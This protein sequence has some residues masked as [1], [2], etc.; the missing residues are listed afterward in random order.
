M[1]LDMSLWI[2]FALMAASVGTIVL[3][4]L[5]PARATAQ[6]VNADLLVYRDQ[7]ATLEAELNSGQ[8]ETSEAETAK[9]EISR[10]LLAAG[11]R[12]VANS[13]LG[14][15]IFSG[16]SFPIFLATVAVL[17]SLGVYALN[18][19]PEFSGVPFAGRVIET[20]QDRSIPALLAQIE[21]HLVQAPED[22]QGWEL[23]APIYLRMGRFNEAVRAYANAGRIL[24]AFETRA[25]QS[26]RESC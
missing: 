6:T 13:N 3:V 15:G 22:G 24:R 5:R 4:A 11:K 2:I 23:I 18:G 25:D 7:L 26:T 20:S 17:F 1:E 10:R 19:K 14:T 9:I 12:S 21:E 8:I 16:P